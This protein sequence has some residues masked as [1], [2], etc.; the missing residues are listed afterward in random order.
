MLDFTKQKK[1]FHPVKMPDGTVLNLLTP[2]KKLFEQI[3]GFENDDGETVHD[4]AE[5]Y[6]VAAGILSTNLQKKQYTADEVGELFDIEDVRALYSEYVEFVSKI[7]NN[8][9]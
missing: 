1:K 6:S 5:L 4:I 7:A 2:K 8:P 3:A 9:N